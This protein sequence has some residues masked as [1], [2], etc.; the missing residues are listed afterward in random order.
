MLPPEATARVLQ[1]ALLHEDDEMRLNA[2]EMVCIHPKMTE[3]P[4]RAELVLVQEFL[5]LN[6]K[7]S[8]SNYRQ[9]CME[10]L[11]KFFM[12]L[13]IARQ[14][15]QTM[16][17]KAQR[18]VRNVK[19]EAFQMPGEGLLTVRWSRRRTSSS[20]GSPSISPPHSSQARP[21]SATS[22]HSSSLSSPSTCGSP[23]GRG[24]RTRRS[25][26]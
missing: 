3:P 25:P 21:L 22:W 8:S 17:R 24:S 5:A 10:L 11:K 15:I 7:S 16:C 1:A 23:R 6:M 26:R 18:G 2:L 14:H 20:H 12:R 9:K 4:T 19:K 13:R